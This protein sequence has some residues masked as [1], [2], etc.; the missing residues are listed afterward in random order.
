IRQHR[1][2]SIKKGTLIEIKVSQEL[3]LVAKVI[4]LEVQRQTILL[5]IRDELRM[6][7]LKPTDFTDSFVDLT[8][9][10]SS[11]QS[12]IIQ[13]AVKNGGAIL[14][15]RLP[16]FKGLLKR[17]LMPGIRLGTELAKRAVFWGRGG[18][19][20]HSDELPGYGITEC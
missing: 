12:K 15:T 18:G 4:E 7:S 17:E 5:Q 6:R 13:S 1:D 19:I 9:Q 16:G 2:E 14:G 20:L 11:S 8:E 10:L 3:Q